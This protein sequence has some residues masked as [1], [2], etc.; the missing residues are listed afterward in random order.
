MKD[1]LL[2][3]KIYLSNSLSIIASTFFIVLAK[4]FGN[5]ESYKNFYCSMIVE[6]FEDSL[7][8]LLINDNKM[9]LK[10]CEEIIY[11][12]IS[13]NTI[14]LVFF[15]SIRNDVFDKCSELILRKFKWKY[16]SR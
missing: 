11:V 9:S 8:P 16:N 14:P 6:G 1:F 13:Y 7:L 2:I 4:I 5:T 12:A 10:D 15:P 3:S